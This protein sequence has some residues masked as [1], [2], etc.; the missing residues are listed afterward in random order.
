MAPFIQVLHNIASVKASEAVEEDREK[1]FEEQLNGLMESERASFQC[2][3]YDPKR[4]RR[5]QME[6]G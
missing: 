1:W 5:K 6:K 4:E 3:R 2:E